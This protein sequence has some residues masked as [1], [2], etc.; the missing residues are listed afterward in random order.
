MQ[1]VKP[2]LGPFP[3]YPCLA[4]RRGCEL[5]RN[6]DARNSKFHSARSWRLAELPL[7]FRKILRRHPAPAEI[8]RDSG[9]EKIPCPLRTSGNR[10]KCARVAARPSC[11]GYGAIGRRFGLAIRT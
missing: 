10:W 3:R 4:N 5:I 2:A 8:R 11:P 6:Q 1:I 9:E 7:S